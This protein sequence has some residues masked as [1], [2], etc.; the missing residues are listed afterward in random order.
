MICC[1]VNTS[2]S[3]TDI[4]SRTLRSIRARPIRNWLASNSPTARIRRLPKWS[5]SSTLPRPSARLRKYDISA[6]ISAGVSARALSSGFALPTIVTTRSG[7]T[8]DTTLNF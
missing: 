1:G 4:R 2:L 5:I 7:S 8:G 3:C 6:K